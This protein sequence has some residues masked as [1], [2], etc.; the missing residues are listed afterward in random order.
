MIYDAYRAVSKAE[1]K[2]CK[3]FNNKF[4][5]KMSDQKKYGNGIAYIS[6]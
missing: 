4:P 3:S 6:T 1:N 5:Y 2:I